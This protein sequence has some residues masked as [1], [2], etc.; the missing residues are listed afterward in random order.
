MS[1]CKFDIPF[2]SSAAELVEK[3]KKAITKAGGEV[4]GDLTAGVF[5]IPSPLGSIGG[6]Y[7]IGAQAAT[8]VITS[9]PMFVGCGLI[10][11]TIHK[12]LS[13]KIA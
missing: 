5:S 9:K 12:F 2:E 10:E 6:N 8:F 4:T 1:E 13:E 11:S 7:S 3:A